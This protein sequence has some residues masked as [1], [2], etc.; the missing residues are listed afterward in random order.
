MSRLIIKNLPKGMKEE[1]LRKIFG[2]FGVLTDCSLK[3]T[4]DGVFRRFAFIGYRTEEDAEAVIQH[5]NKTF[6]DTS[7]IQVELAKDFGDS[8]KPRAWSKYSQESSAYKKKSYNSEKEV[9]TATKKKTEKQKEAQKKAVH[10]L[11]GELKDDEGFEEFVE[12]HK[13]KSSKPVWMDELTQGHSKDQ[14]LLSEETGIEDNHSDE[15]NEDEDSGDEAEGTESGTTKDEP[16]MPERKS[17]SDRSACKKGVSDLEYLKSKMTDELLSGSSSDSNSDSDSESQTITNSRKTKPKTDSPVTGTSVSID[18]VE[19]N[20]DKPTRKYQLKMTSLPGNAKENV[21]REFFQPLRCSNIKLPRNTFK[22]PIGV[23][24]VEFENEADVDQALT[25]MKKN[26]NLIDGKRVYLKKLHNVLKNTTE[27]DTKP[28]L[29]P[30]ELKQE[31]PGVGAED[32]GESGKLFVRNLSYTCTDEDLEAHFG[33]YGPLTEVILPIDSL[34]KKLKGFAFITYMIPEN[35]VTAYSK[36]D[37]SVFQGRMLHILPGKTKEEKPEINEGSSFKNK[38]QADQKKMAGSSHNW[39]TLFLG[40]NAVADVIAEK[41]GT[42]KSQLLN[43]ESSESLGVRLALGETQIVA[44]TR[45]FLVENGVSLDCFSQANAPRSKTVI[46]VKNLPAGTSPQEL[47]DVFCHHG[48]IG[49]LVMPPSGVTAI[50]EYLH[51][52]EAKTGFTRLAYTKFKHVPLY[53]EWA[54]MEIFTK[55]A[56]EVDQTPDQTQ[57]ESMKT[58]EKESSS[59]EESELGSTI[60]VK[61]LN[62]DTTEDSL[63]EHFRKCG[64]IQVVTISKKK[65]VKNPGQL[66]SMGYGFVEF[67][68]KTSADKAVRE[69]Q[70]SDLDGHQL[71]LKIS[72]RATLQP[73]IKEKNKQQKKKQ[74]TTKI[75]VRNIPFEASR[76]EVFELFKVFGELKTVRLPKKLG[77][78]G[79]HRGFAFRAFETLC[80]ST[81]LYGRRLVLEWADTEEDLEDLRRKTAERYHGDS[82]KKKLRKSELMDFLQTS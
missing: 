35:A 1:R 66:L 38:R 2:E 72:N 7:R 30:W 61:N 54:P 4:K 19:D 80:H 32:I 45:E 75:L 57:E 8:N 74:K 82:P 25:R 26:T 58:E 23:A 59:E 9:E 78:T 69:L 27:D 62:F 5:F 55:A 43:A 81:H 41:Y 50:V 33:K 20:K 13:S 12:A 44:E 53:L 63:K 48:D 36:L 39:N 47:R 22:K 18:T 21:I 24:Y 77:G 51:P 28:V 29:R 16:D 46:L 49:R 15:R 14:S 3:F 65:D 60:F 6:I 37:G 56:E 42:T 34:T 79:S 76:K 10:D 17:Q 70:H 71:E 67:R 68:Q 73:K 64:K 40:A 31:D 52:T 11:L